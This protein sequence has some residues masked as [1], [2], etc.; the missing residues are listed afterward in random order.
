MNWCEVLNKWCSD[1]DAADMEEAV[2]DGDC[3][4]CDFCTEE[5]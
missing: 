3:E 5:T 1:I 4:W 2:C